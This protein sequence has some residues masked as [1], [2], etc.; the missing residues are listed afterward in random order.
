MQG[1][2][3]SDVVE[4]IGMRVVTMVVVLIVLA[5]CVFGFVATFEPMDATKQ[6]SWR[7]VY[8]IIGVA[9]V[10]GYVWAVRART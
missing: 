7:A 4:D 3:F 2:G 5:F 8:G 10:G 1:E 6:W 9:C